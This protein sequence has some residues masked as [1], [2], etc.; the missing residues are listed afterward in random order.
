MFVKIVHATQ[1]AR[2]FFIIISI[3]PHKKR[4]ESFSIPLAFFCVKN[5]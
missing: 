2:C 4:T 1:G 5:I 3:P